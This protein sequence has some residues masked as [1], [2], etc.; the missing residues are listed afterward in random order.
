[1]QCVSHQAVSLVSCTCQLVARVDLIDTGV[2][3]GGT[4]VAEWAAVAKCAEGEE[5]G[6]YHRP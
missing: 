3:V 1:M 4:E 6:A 2:F 5:P